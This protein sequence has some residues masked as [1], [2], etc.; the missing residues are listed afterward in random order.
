MTRRM[1]PVNP[2]ATLLLRSLPWNPDLQAKNLPRNRPWNPN[3][4][5]LSENSTPTQDFSMGHLSPVYI[6]KY[7]K[8]SDPPIFS[9]LDEHTKEAP[10]RDTW[11]IRF[12]VQ[13][14]ILEAI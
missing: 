4:D 2:L 6:V 11:K 9:T 3:Y 1:K 5:T 14:K 13:D 12:L 7:Q 8:E 10:W